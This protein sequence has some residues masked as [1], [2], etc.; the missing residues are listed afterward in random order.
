MDDNFDI[1]EKLY[2]A[3]YPPEYLA[4]FWRKDGSLSSAAFADPKGLSVDRGNHR[5]D[6]DVVVYM[7]KKFTGRIIYLYVK[8]CYDT[9][10]VV[11]YLPSK[12]N[13]YHSEIHGSQTTILLS[14]S[15]R[16]YLAKKARVL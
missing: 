9:G 2:R 11:R 13:K 5:S 14:K 7:Q 3:V 1:K 16:L 8:H 6:Q 12:S 15:Q 10:A 4:M